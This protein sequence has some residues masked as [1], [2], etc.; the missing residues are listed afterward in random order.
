MQT[1]L[2]DPQ[3]QANKWLHKEIEDVKVI[4]VET[5]KYIKEIIMALKFG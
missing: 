1:L 5:T 3:G 2:I 4:N